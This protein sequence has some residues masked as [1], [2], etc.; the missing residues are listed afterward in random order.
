MVGSGGS[1]VSGIGYVVEGGTGVEVE[2][3]VVD[4]EEVGEEVVVLLELDELE[5]E[6]SS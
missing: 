6:P 1:G 5:D 3:P 4:G 2:G